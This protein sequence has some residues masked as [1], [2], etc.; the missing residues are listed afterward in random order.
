MTSTNPS[1]SASPSIAQSYVPSKSSSPS[2]GPS[3][4]P[5]RSS[6][7]SNAPNQ[8][9]SFYPTTDPTLSKTMMP[10][11]F[12][13]RNPTNSPTSM[14]LPI[15]ALPIE[16]SQYEG[17]SNIINIILDIQLG[18]WGN[19]GSN[20]GSSSSSS[21]SSSSSSS[22]SSSL[23]SQSSSGSSQSSSVDDAT[24]SPSVAPT[25]EQIAKP[26]VAPTGASFGNSF[27]TSSDRPN[28]SLSVSMEP[29]TKTL[30]P[31]EQASGVP[32][33]SLK[34]TS[35]PT[36]APT[37]SQTTA[38]ASPTSMPSPMKYIHP[39]AETREGSLP[40]T[41]M[42]TINTPKVSKR[43][44]RKRRKRRKGRRRKRLSR[45]VGPPRVLKDLSDNRKE[46]SGRQGEGFLEKPVIVSRNHE[47]SR[48]LRGSKP[49]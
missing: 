37:L 3:E 48:G 14:E 10:S 18:N 16:G 39:T 30:E 43:T 13:T 11:P 5:S 4:L 27:M 44:R 9:P 38:S 15:E 36:G 7:P 2:A 35:N 17:I 22:S 42:P 46:S 33:L 6:K 28:S 40:S 49:L 45:E 20:G 1:L 34:F 29:S 24:R 26:S 47:A 19:F 21:G 41:A 31:S 12:P 25:L 23:S 32:S 8:K